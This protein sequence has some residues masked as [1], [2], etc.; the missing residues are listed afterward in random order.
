[1]TAVASGT[2]R[3]TRPHRSAFAYGG[4]PRSEPHTATIS[5]LRVPERAAAYMRNRINVRNHYGFRLPDLGGA[6]RG[7]RDAEV[8]DLDEDG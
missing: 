8:A 1:M 2:T 6:W 7:L 3:R 5:P 4:L